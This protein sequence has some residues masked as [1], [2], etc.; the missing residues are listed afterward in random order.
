MPSNHT[1]TC[2]P[3]RFS[4][5]QTTK[6]PYCCNPMTYMGKAFKPP[7]KSNDTQ[8]AKVALMVAHSETFGYCSC[9]RPRKTPQTLGEAKTLY[10]ERRS[11][12]RDYAVRGVKE[13]QITRRKLWKGRP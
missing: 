5:K 3:C 12:E 7:K 13:E 10:R 11:D 6:C 1:Y 2:V 9:H 4:A 8:W